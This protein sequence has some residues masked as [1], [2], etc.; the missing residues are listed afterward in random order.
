M[1]TSSSVPGN[2]VPGVDNPYW[3]NG[4]ADHGRRLAGTHDIWVERLF[5]AGL[6]LE[7]ALGLIGEH[8]AAENVREALSEL[9]LGIRDLRDALFAS[10]PDYPDGWPV[11]A[12]MRRVP[13]P[14]AAPEDF[15]AT[16]RPG[17]CL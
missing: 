1:P 13:D 4:S 6:A 8:P 14:M 5:R 10:Q 9:E 11:Q 15:T 3:A 2:G 17:K 16:A 7:T 12:H